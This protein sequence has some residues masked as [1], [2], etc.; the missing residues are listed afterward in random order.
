[1]TRRTGR[2]LRVRVGCGWGPVRKGSKRREWIADGG[3]RW[4]RDWRGR[5]RGYHSGNGMDRFTFRPGTRPWFVS[6]RSPLT[7]LTYL[8]VRY[9]GP[10]G[11]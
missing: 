7:G 11:S 5:R 1:M 9:V 4:R 6:V 10:V 8:P 2:G 3:E